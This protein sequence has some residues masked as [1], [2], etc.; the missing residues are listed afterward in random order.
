M[1]TKLKSWCINVKQVLNYYTAIWAPLEFAMCG[2]ISMK[3]IHSQ[4][5]FEKQSFNLKD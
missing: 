3:A 5:S 2:D 1:E 4:E